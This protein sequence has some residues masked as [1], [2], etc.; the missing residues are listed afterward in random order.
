MK[1]RARPRSRRPRSTGSTFRSIGPAV[2]GGRVIDIEVN[3]RDHSEYY[4]ASGHGSLW[5][6]TND[7]VTLLAGVRRAVVVLDR[8]PS[9]SIPRIR[10]SSG[11]DRRE[12]RRIRTSCRRRRL[13][14]RGRRKELG[15]Q[16][17]QGIP[18]DR[19][20]RR[21]T[22][23]IRTRSGWRRYGPHRTSGGDRGVFKTTD[24]GKTWKNVL[25]PSDN[26]GCWELHM[27]PRNPDV[28]YTVA[29]Q[30]QRYLTTIV[31]GG[32]ES[33]IYKTMDGGTTW[34]RLEGG[35][36]QKDWSGGSAWTSR[37]SIPT[38]STRWWTPRRRRTRGPTDEPRRGR[39]L[40]PHE[41]L[42]HLLSRL[43]PEA[44]L[45]PENIDRVYAHG[46][47]QPGFDR[48]R[49]DL[50]A[51]RRGSEARGQPRALDRPGRSAAPALRVRRRRLRVVRQGRHLGLQGQPADG[52]GLQGDGG[53]R[54]AL[55]QRLHRH[56]GQQQPRRPVADDQFERDHERRLGLHA[57][58][59]TASRRRSTGRI[60]TSSM[61]RR[62][63]AALVRYDRK[64]GERLY[65]RGF[66]GEGQPAYRFD[67]DTPLLGVA[68]RPQAHL[69]GREQAAPL[70]RPGGE[71]A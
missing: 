69:P 3:P 9:R 11:W 24:G 6:T 17:A 34:K 8:L 13:P 65:L 32:D 42:R 14:E 45:R 20:D 60:R 44:L 55:L 2:T 22:R 50:V 23:V 19:R 16:G 70:G 5:K 64:T 40:D 27:D 25:H 30:R 49:Q 1:R 47:L 53:Q 43:L 7:G 62:S 28:L 26:T 12:Q 56:P 39:E 31:T 52:R 36:P 38:G 29:H 67:W 51:P 48:R 71:L 63:S 58:G 10:T 59:A 61:P 21:C 46:R 4:V 68:S 18:A 41:R 33:A 15:E 66:E 57:R 54:E 35:L 37:R